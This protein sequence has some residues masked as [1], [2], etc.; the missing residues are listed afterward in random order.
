M[1]TAILILMLAQGTVWGQ[2]TGAQVT[3]CSSKVALQDIGEFPVI[4]E[5]LMP[6]TLR[7]GITKESLKTAVE[8]RLRSLG[9]PVKEKITNGWLSVE[10]NSV[11]Q[12]TDEASACGYIVDVHFKLVTRSLKSSPTYCSPSIWTRN[13]VGVGNV[14]FLRNDWQFRVLTVVDLFANDYLAANP[15]K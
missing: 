11:C 7:L 15:K 3:T 14:V 1:K 2:G 10:F 4:I 12:S 5:E 6:A 8:L 9:L 13:L